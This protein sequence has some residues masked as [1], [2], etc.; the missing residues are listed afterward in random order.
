MIPID[1]ACYQCSMVD[2]WYPWG[3]LIDAS[4]EGNLGE[5]YS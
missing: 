4:M 2:H 3:F 5:A 1:L